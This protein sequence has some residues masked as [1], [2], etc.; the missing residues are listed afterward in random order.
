LEETELWGTVE[1]ADCLMMYHNLRMT[2]KTI[3][4]LEKCRLIVRCGVGVDNVDHAFAR[5]RGIPVCNVPDYGTEEVADNA[6]GMTL[7]LT[8]GVHF[9]NSRLKRSVGEWKY[10]QITPLHRLR[11]ET[12]GIIGL[13]RIGSAAALRAK[14]LGM[15]VIFYDP[16]VPDGK[17][18]SLGVTRVD[19]LEEVL[20]QAYVISPHC[21][22]TDETRHIMNAETIGA[23][24]KGSY[25]INTSRGGVVDTA[26]IPDAIAAGRLAGAGID[27]LE[28][29]PA[30][31][32]DPLIAAWRDPDHPCH[33]RLIVNPHSAFY[34]E[35]GLMEIRT[36]AST[37]CLRALK[38][39][40]LRNVVN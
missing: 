34:C 40:T 13:G 39:E 30:K 5:T 23:M 21:P 17:D 33:D 32:D 20:D 27:V 36:K 6:I 18:K 24:R 25:L 28:V 38:G 7:T 31:D 35:E 3:E 16:Y 4:R 22:L 19:T 10:T 29:E 11:G 9:L 8:R 2:A 14:A 15:N 26:A 1:D 37:N 12:F